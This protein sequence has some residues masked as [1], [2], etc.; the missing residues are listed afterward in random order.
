VLTRWPDVNVHYA[1]Q[2]RHGIL[3]SASSQV[4]LVGPDG[5][6]EVLARESDPVVAVDPD[7]GLVAVAVGVRGRQPR[8][9]LTLVDLADGWRETM[10]W[11]VADE[12][13]EV[14]AVHGGAVYANARSVETTVRWTPG[15]APEI[16]PYHVEEVDP[17]SG[18]AL[19]FRRGQGMLVVT[20]EGAVR[21]VPQARLVPGGDRLCALQPG[22]VEVWPVDDP[23]QLSAYRLPAGAGTT[24]GL[25]WESRRHLLLPG[26]RPLRLDVD[27][28][29]VEAVPLTGDTAERPVFVRP[30][31]SA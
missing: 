29:E 27:T 9:Q 5:T 13:F 14:T 12:H 1:F 11:S 30:L 10:P 7:G 22:K 8:S 24:V 20:P 15:A 31:P 26:E 18:A 28:G 19:A 23:Q 17:H 21:P 3:L 6:L 2:T 16:L 25:V 4:A